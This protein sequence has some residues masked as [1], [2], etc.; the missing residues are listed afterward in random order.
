MKKIIAI[1]SL[2]VLVNAAIIAQICNLSIS[3][4]ASICLGMSTTLS[5]SGGSNY[6]WNPSVN[7]SSSVGAVVIASPTIT[8]SYTVTAGGCVNSISVNITVYSLPTIMVSTPTSICQGLSTSLSVA[9]ANSYTWFPSATLNSSIGMTINASP[10]VSTTYSV[11]GTNING[12]INSAVTSVGVYPQPVLTG[13]ANTS[14]CTGFSTQLSTGGAVT[15]LWSPFIGINTNSGTN[16]TANPTAT[17][18]YTITGTNS[19][20]CS[21][22]NLITVNVNATPT[23]TISGV[24]SICPGSSDLLTALGSPGNHYLWSTGATTPAISVSAPGTLTVTAMGATGCIN[25]AFAIVTVNS[26]PTISISGNLVIC[27]GA[28]TGLTASGAISYIW[29]PS[30]GLNSNTG[31]SITAV[32]SVTTTYT[33]SGVGSNGCTGMTTVQVIL[34]KVVAN[35]GVNAVICVGNPTTLNATGGNFYQWTPSATLSSSTGATVSADPTATTNYTVTV[36]DAN[37]CIGTNSVQVAVAAVL[38]ANPGP[39]ASICKGLGVPLTGQGGSTYL[40]NPSVGLS[41][42]TGTFV[43]ASPT[44]TTTYSLVAMSGVCV[45]SPASLLITVNSLPT[46][47]LNGNETICSGKSTAL[48]AAGA[49]SFV[50]S[51]STGLNTATG[52]TVTANSANS[53]TYIVM[54]TDVNGCQNVDSVNVSVISLPTV[55]VS[56][57]FTVCSGTTVTLSAIGSAIA[58]SWS[59]GATTQTVSV[60]PVIPTRY[61]VSI[62]GLN[63]C[64]NSAS[65]SVAVNPIPT[66][67]ISG[68]ATVCSVT[69]TTLTATTP[70]TVSSYLWSTG[71]TVQ[72][73][74]VSTSGEYSVTV[75]SS[76]GCVGSTSVM[77]SLNTPLTIAVSGNLT[78]CNGQS[79]NLTVSGANIFTWAPPTGLTF[80]SSS[81]NNVTANPNLT[82]TYYL[83][84]TTNNCIGTKNVTITVNLCTTGITE[85]TSVANSLTLYP[86]PANSYVDLKF[87]LSSATDVVIK[88]INVTGQ[89]VYLDSKTQ[90]AAGEY[91]VSVDVSNI[92]K[93]MYFM[94]IVTN[95]EKVNRK[96][97][98]D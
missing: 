16:V 7:Q 50:W 31:A 39:N 73:I 57:A 72:A 70:V 53:I 78:I 51:P 3:P 89:T 26:L 82:T 48:V 77:A 93:G 59:T 25:S 64:N 88:L 2:C 84:G 90:Q 55:S 52:S 67:T 79:T 94:E 71:A 61:T 33:V 17:I 81:D 47:T 46:I 19:N 9:G 6:T 14:I 80:N 22:T 12:C 63:G 76:S 66:I 41:S 65:D 24:T 68:K 28:A 56:G 91:N 18:T 36:T 34:D 62:I 5:V 95:T 45:S 69:S 8:T 37:G 87:G 15:Y 11:I 92:P 4:N 38:T 98:V 58:Y 1:I 29:L 13:S 60:V 74:T 35:A 97:V 42:I 75:T 32:P 49:L 21:T 30:S 85:E 44:V 43:M 40:W 23:V 20:G 86:N 96:V 83:T 54:G 27:L 10:S